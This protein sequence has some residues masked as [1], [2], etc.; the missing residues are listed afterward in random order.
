MHVPM[1]L[2]YKSAEQIHKTNFSARGITFPQHSWLPNENMS[3]KWDTITA[4]LA[5]KQSLS[6]HIKDQCCKLLWQYCI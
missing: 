3:D 6:A 1:A 2:K 5:V 4:C